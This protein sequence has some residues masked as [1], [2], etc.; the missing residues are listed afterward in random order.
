[1]FVHAHLKS[2]YEHSADCFTFKDLTADR[3]QPLLGI[4]GGSRV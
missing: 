4:A 3:K 2:Q 1:M